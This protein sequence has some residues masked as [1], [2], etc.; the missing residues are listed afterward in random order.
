MRVEYTDEAR[1]DLR[2]FDKTVAVRVIKKIS[3]YASADD[4]RKH[5]KS[6]TGRLAGLYRFR[7]GDYRVIFSIS[8][9]GTVSILV[10]L[11]IAHRKDIY[12]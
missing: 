2:S 1:K 9:D 10:V 5:A 12:R 4:P 7:V 3:V 8:G 11:A 6:L